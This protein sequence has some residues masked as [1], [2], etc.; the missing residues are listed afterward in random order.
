M[1]PRVAKRVRY[2]GNVQGV[3]FRRRTEQIARAFAV[4]GYVQNLP[5]GSVELVAEGEAGPVAGLLDAVTRKMEAEIAR[6]AVE[7][8]PSEAFTTFEIRR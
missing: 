2:F 8:V 5:D 1:P 6:Q 4:A 3:G 7:D